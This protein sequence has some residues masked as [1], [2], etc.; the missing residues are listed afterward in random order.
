MLYPT[1]LRAHR[2]PNCTI[3]GARPRLHAAHTTD[4]QMPQMNGR[5]ATAQIRE[6]KRRTI[7]RTPLAASRPR[8]RNLYDRPAAGAPCNTAR[9]PLVRPGS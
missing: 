7:R 4:V 1:E 5:E 9:S 8:L 6:T 3:R 2:N